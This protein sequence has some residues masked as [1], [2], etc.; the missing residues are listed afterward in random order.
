MN[1]PLKLLK[2]PTAGKNKPGPEEYIQILENY[3]D[4]KE[5]KE[6]LGIPFELPFNI[7]NDKQIFSIE[8]NVVK[9]RSLLITVISITTILISILILNFIFFINIFLFLLVILILPLAV[10]CVYFV[11]KS[12]RANTIPLEKVKFFYNKQKNTLFIPYW[13]MEIPHSGILEFR[14]F[15][16]KRFGKDGVGGYLSELSVIYKS[17][18]KII[19]APLFATNRSQSLK[20]AQMLSEI[21]GIK[22][23]FEEVSIPFWSKPLFS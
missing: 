12:A 15:Y 18:Q 11:D 19:R 10:L 9:D 5:Q 13:S 23:N 6:F 8:L 7:V 16:E 14:V 2:K 4:P 17:G 1:K 22:Y 20:I 3:P 21:T